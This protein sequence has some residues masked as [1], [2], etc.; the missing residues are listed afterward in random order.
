MTQDPFELTR[1]VKAQN[2]EDSHHRGVTWD[3]ITAELTTGHKRGHWMWF[4][5]PQVDLG[6]TPTSHHFAIRSRDE[7]VAYLT[8]PVLGPRLRQCTRLI[9]GSGITDPVAIFGHTDSRK[10]R[11]SLTLFD[12]ISPDDVFAEAL[13]MFFAGDADPRTLTYLQTFPDPG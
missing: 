2:G 4:V 5:F 1:F 8:H 9:V 11:S 13:R 10:L 3:S 7:A 6:H 12:A